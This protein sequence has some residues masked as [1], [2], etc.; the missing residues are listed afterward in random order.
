M[1][2][3]GVGLARNPID[4]YESPG[5]DRVRHRAPHPIAAAPVIPPASGTHHFSPS[6]SPRQAQHPLAPAGFPGGGTSRRIM[7]LPA[8]RASRSCSQASPEITL[9]GYLSFPLQAPDSFSAIGATRASP[10]LLSDS[11]SAHSRAQAKSA[12]RL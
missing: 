11:L 3:P 4:P 12:F 5:S 8:Q 9:A 2:S 6:T 1:G 10:E 7:Q